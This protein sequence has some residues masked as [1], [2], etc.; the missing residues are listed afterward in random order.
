MPKKNRLIEFGFVVLAVVAAWNLQL[1]SVGLRIAA[2]LGFKSG[3]FGETMTKDVFVPLSVALIGILAQQ[4]FRTVLWRFT[5]A[6]RRYSGT[7]VYTCLAHVAP[8]EEIHTV[9]WFQLRRDF[10]NAAIDNARVYYADTDDLTFRGSWFGHPVWIHGDEIGIIF[11]MDGGG[12]TRE[13]V[14]SRYRGFM[15]LRPRPAI[16]RDGAQYWDGHFHDLGDRAGIYG[17]VVAMKVKGREALNPM[18]AIQAHREEIWTALLQRV[19]RLP[20][21]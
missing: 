13:P 21:V 10:G 19:G 4:L 15:D 8:D 6:S 7:W 18:E 17:P 20:T 1:N 9:G 5:R 3:S 2:N 16:G 12:Q 11:D 14:P